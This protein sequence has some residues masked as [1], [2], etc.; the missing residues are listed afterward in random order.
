MADINN[1]DHPSKNAIEPTR[2]GISA[3]EMAV[4]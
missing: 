2:L 1:K 4:H 3:A